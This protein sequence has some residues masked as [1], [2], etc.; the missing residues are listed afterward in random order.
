M[1][2]KILSVASLIGSSL[3]APSADVTA[4]CQYLESHYP[5]YFAWDPTQHI[6][7]INASVYNDINKSYWNVVNSDL[8]A[9]CAFFPETVDQVADVVKQLGK[10]PDAPFA[11]KSGG[12]QPAPGFSAIE[13]GVLISFEPNL[14][15]VTRS[16]GGKHFF[17]GP[18]ARWGDVYEVTGRT[19]QVVVGGRLANIGVG[20][21]TLGGGLSYHSAQYVCLPLVPYTIEIFC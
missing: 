6:P 19:K 21:Y 11:L 10:H 16:E 13:D 7:S 20:G 4:V 2:L 14:N 9:S 8:R 15:H 17:V 1:L 5:A 3:A 12:H 18:G